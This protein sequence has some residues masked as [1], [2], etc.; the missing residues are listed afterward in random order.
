M[1][2]LTNTN[3]HKKFKRARL[4]P[5]KLNFFDNKEFF[6]FL[7]AKLGHFI[8]DD[9]F[10]YARNTQTKQQK[11]ENQEKKFYRIG[12]SLVSRK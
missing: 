1:S 7:A 10:P 8:I 9:F 6:C 12:Y 4:N 2:S 5:I 11:L 3:N